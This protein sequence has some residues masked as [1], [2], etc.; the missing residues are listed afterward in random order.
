ME[1]RTM[2]NHLAIVAA[3]VLTTFTGLA[4]ADDTAELKAKVAELQAKVDA[5]EA[6]RAATAQH[7]QTF[8]ELDLEAFNSR[9]MKRIKEIHA[10]DVM[11]YNPDGTTTS[12]TMPSS[13]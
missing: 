7:L 1:E 11:V 8:D 9:D 3:L 4:H 12:P 6:E 13:G 10:D 2:K 5:H